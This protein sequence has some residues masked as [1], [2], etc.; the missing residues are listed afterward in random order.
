MSAI[1]KFT[2][3]LL[4]LGVT[5]ATQCCFPRQYEAFQGIL[6]TT[7][8]MNKPTVLAVSDLYLSY[9]LLSSLQFVMFDFVV[10]ILDSANISYVAINVLELNT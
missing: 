1:L 7:F 8:E 9:L 6:R 10:A 2:A 3:V 4:V 5:S